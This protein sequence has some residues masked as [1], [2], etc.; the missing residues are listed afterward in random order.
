MV[1]TKPVGAITRGTTHP[2]R[3]RRCDRWL[4]ATQARRLRRHDGPPIVVD[5]GYGASPITAL[6]LHERLRRVRADVDVVG[7]EIDPAR[8]AAAQPLARP[9][10]SFALGGFEVPLPGDARP[11]LVRAFNVLRQYAE[12]DVQGA[13]D[14]VLGRLAPDG[15]F[16]DGTC[17]ELGRLSTWVALD[18]TGP[19]TL[20]L[21]WRLA[22][23]DRPSVIAERLPKALIHRNVPGEGI[24]RFLTDLDDQWARAASHASWGARQRFRAMAEA[25][26]YAGWPFIDGPSRWRLGELTVAWAAVAPSGQTSPVHQGP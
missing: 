24:H 8:V 5:L 1:A 10:V 20:T 15:L 17:D 7:L 12:G 3:L 18:T 22:G 19:Q 2:N 25:M 16:V 6:E 21:S 4:S 14:R 13:W 23:L 11:V 26:R 9:G